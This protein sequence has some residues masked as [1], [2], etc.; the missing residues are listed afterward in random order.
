LVTRCCCDHKPRR[1][2]VMTPRISAR[3]DNTSYAVLQLWK[4]PD[5]DAATREAAGQ[6]ATRRT[7]HLTARLRGVGR[8][9]WT[10]YLIYHSVILCCFA[11]KSPSA[12][13]AGTEAPPAGWTLC[14][15]DPYE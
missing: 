2:I 7:T 10:D 11:A 8:S 12:G 1:C 5:D 15:L 14:G 13:H 9:L 6:R 3:N 4:M